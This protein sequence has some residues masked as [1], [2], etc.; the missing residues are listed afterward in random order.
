MSVPNGMWECPGC[1]TYLADSRTVCPRCGAKRYPGQEDDAKE[2]DVSQETVRETPKEEV[3]SFA[4][5]TTW[6]AEP[7]EIAAIETVAK[8]SPKDSAAARFLRVIAWILWIGGFIV[9]ILK[10]QDAKIDRWGDTH[11]SFA[12][13]LET[14][15]E[16]GLYGGFTMCAS[17]LFENVQ[18]IANALQG[19]RITKK[20]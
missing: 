19:F 6:N 7:Q 8:A 5:K 4:R 12:V 10:A 3:R 18:T 15:I 11:F 2:K 13:F 16:Y 14:L 20:D 1:H 9:S 17:E